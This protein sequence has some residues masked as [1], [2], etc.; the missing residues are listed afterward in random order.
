MKKQLLFWSQIKLHKLKNL[1]KKEKN[2]MTKTSFSKLQKDLANYDLPENLDNLEK[3]KCG[4][5][6]AGKRLYWYCKED[7]EYFEKN[8]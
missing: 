1:N 3:L 2:K 4:A 6:E 8:R 7:A 5:L